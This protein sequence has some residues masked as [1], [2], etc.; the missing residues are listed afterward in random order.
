M[1]VYIVKILLHGYSRSVGNIIIAGNA[2][3]TK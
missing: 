2:K 3:K 1:S